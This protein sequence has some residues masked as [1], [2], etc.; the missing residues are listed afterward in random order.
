M[1]HPI[2]IS[3]LSAVLLGV[4][5]AGVDIAGAETVSLANGSIFRDCPDCPEIVVIPT[6]TFTMGSTPEETRHANLREDIAPREWPARRVTIPKAFGIGRFEISRAE[7]GRFVSASGHPD[8]DAC[9]T[10][11]Q[12]TDKW[13]QVTGASWRKP[14]FPQDERHPVGCLDLADARAYVA[15]LSAATGQRYRIPT[16]AEWEYVARAGTTTLQSWGDS[17]DDVCLHANSSD[18]DRADAHGGLEA[19]PTRFF[20]CRDG[21]VYTA[22]VGSYP[23]NQFG[24]YD[25][26]GNVWEWVE[27]CFYP[28]Y[29]GAP[30]DS[31][32]WIHEGCDRLVV[33]GGGWFSRV[34]FVRP[35]GR[36]REGPEYR[37]MTLG[38]R[39]LRELP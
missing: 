30:A 6:G 21:F 39:V 29:Q 25:V 7:Y 31:S 32:A 9:I 35:A 28:T 15:W 22:P 23:A 10:W 27:D 37:S 17:F 16:E 36:S 34:W 20:D 8:G 38:L 18:L 11:N 1:S 12:A 24:L 5:L 33:R 26:I 4:G 19:E 3:L 2:R 14:G 13:E